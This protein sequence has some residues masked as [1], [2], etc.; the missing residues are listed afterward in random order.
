MITPSIH[1]SSAALIVTAVMS[2]TKI[3]LAILI[4]AMSLT[5]V[6]FRVR[7]GE[8]GLCHFVFEIPEWAPWCGGTVP[9]CGASWLGSGTLLEIL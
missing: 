7:N 5:K 2:L 9:G 1:D 6:T 3:T 8:F 4:A